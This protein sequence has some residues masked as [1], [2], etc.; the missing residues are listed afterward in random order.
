ML[1]RLYLWTILVTIF[2]SPN[3]LAKSKSPLFEQS[4]ID[5]PITVDRAPLS[6][7]LSASPSHELAIIGSDEQNRKTLI[8]SSFKNKESKINKTFT[9]PSQYFAY[10][11]GVKDSAGLQSLY[12]LAQDHIAQ[13]NFI[14]NTLTAIHEI[15]SMY[16]MPSSPYLRE[17]NFAQDI[18]KDK[19]D[20]FIVQDISQLTVV[21]SW[22]SNSKIYLPIASRAFLNSDGVAYDEV[23]LF[24]EDFNFD[25]LRDIA[26]VKQG[27][28]EY[29]AAHATKGFEK[30]ATTIAINSSIRSLN[31]WDVRQADG[32]TLDQ[33]ELE[34]RV[35][36][37]IQDVNGDGLADMVVRYTKSSGVL[38][39]VND[40]E[41]YFGS[42]GNPSL[43][44]SQ[45][46][47]TEIS[48]EGTLAG[49]ELR[50]INKDGQLEVVVS[51]FD[52]GVSEIIGALLSGSIDQDIFIYQLDEKL[53]YKTK[54]IASFETEMSFS[55]SK[56]KTG[57]PII[58]LADINGDNNDDVVLSYSE[59]KLATR[60][61]T[62]NKKRAFTRSKKQKL[63]LPMSGENIV[64]ADLNNDGAEEIVMF[65]GRLDKPQQRQ[66]ISVLFA[67]ST[68]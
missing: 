3:I 4:I 47:N 37:K 15:S 6:A 2:S 59:T 1:T 26:V 14:S 28:I 30:K 17:I 21:P 43:F 12:F 64:T 20:D 39:R 45:T 65:F 8:I 7:N 49:L 51:S 27:A 24:I 50:D 66:K 67:K 60:L 32:E 61:A 56:G 52:I 41:F 58:A 5:L 46:A 33:N 34:Y 16:K 10:D 42:N 18:N 35:V 62:P 68:L 55:L 40:Y 25:G 23:P 53:N 48:A 9:I 19:V 63:V 11:L 22:L 38:D 13:Y 36:D 44:F 54:P 31:W 57:E 29:F